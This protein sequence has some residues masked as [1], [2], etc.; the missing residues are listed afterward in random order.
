[1]TTTMQTLGY[2][3]AEG[4]WVL[5]TAFLDST[6][7]TLNALGKER[8]A[9]YLRRV[10]QELKSQDP[11]DW[12]RELHPIAPG[13]SDDDADAPREPVAPMPPGWTF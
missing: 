10:V 7:P 4:E 5:W 3:H 9:S 6:L 2:A 8:A 1:M 13:E 11:G 12:W